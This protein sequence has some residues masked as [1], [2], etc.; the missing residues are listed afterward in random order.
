MQPAP[1]RTFLLATRSSDKAREIRAILGPTFGGSVITPDDAGI[2]P[3]PE[4][5]GIEVFDTFLGNAHAKADYFRRRSGLDTVADDSGICVPALGGAPGVRSR[6]FAG[7]PELRGHALDQANNEHLLRE[8][9]D[10]PRQQRHAFYAC[11]A[12]LHLAD[13]R[14]FAAIGT[15]AGFILDYPRGTRGFG[16]DPLFLDPASGLTFAEL[17]PAAKNARSHRSRAFRSLAANL[18]A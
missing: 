18:P 10:L 4:E 6:R 11:A 7:R 13:G 12:V 5:D 3:A 15:C 2:D 8:L 14:R 17:D 9:R 16:Y 1:A